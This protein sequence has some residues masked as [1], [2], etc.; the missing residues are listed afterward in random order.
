MKL[1]MMEILACPA[2]RASPLELEV[3]KEKA[4]EVD[5]GVMTCPGCGARYEISD[6]VPDM[7]PK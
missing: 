7:V 5:E 2:C 4:G 6:G 3:A 1:R